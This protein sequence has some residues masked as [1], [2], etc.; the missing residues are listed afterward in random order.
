MAQ[1]RPIVTKQKQSERAVLNI[2]T[3]ALKDALAF[4]EIYKGD[5]QQA[6]WGFFESELTKL[7]SSYVAVQKLSI[8]VEQL[9]H[10]VARN[11]MTVA[12]FEEE[13]QRQKAT[14]C[15]PSAADVNKCRIMLEF[16]RARE[17]KEDEDEIEVMDD[18]QGNTLGLCP[19]SQQ[20]LDVLEP[21][22]LFS[23]PACRHTYSVKVFD[24]FTNGKGN[25]NCPKPGCGAR[26]YKARL[27]P[28][29]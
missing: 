10:S 25:V 7:V 4:M 24:L 26:V 13:L 20:S 12:A 27:K 19:V 17:Q 14:I 11:T 18:D 6:K 16:R 1:Y 22:Q 15:K 3:A 23:S 28:L 29:G 8:A 2:A 21:S 9:V 5:D